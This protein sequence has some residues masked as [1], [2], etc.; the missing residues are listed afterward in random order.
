MIKPTMSSLCKDFTH[1]SNVKFYTGK[2]KYVS[3][4]RRAEFGERR[5]GFFG[6]N[7]DRSGCITLGLGGISRKI[8]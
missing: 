5:A 7:F 8:C 2:L 4:E 6:I 1:N 3:G